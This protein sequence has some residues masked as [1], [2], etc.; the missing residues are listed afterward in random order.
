MGKDDKSNFAASLH[1]AERATIIAFFE[2]SR[3]S[4]YLECLADPTRRGRQLDRLNHCRDLL[5]KYATP[6]ADQSSAES[7]LRSRGAPSTCHAISDCDSIDGL[8]LPLDEALE[9]IRFGGWGTLLVCIPGR[10]AYYY[11]EQGDREFIL[12]R[13]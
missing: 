12:E 8:D 13:T 1:P 7:L 6:V 5:E 10:L 9:K 3:R 4:R 11:D 2:P